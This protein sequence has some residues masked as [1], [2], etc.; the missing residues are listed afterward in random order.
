MLNIV[1]G[2]QAL[3]QDLSVRTLLDQVPNQ[4]L[5]QS[6]GLQQAHFKASSH[7]YSAHHKRSELI[8]EYLFVS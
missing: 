4:A 2:K 7:L 5:Y 6:Q 1:R 3:P 8:E